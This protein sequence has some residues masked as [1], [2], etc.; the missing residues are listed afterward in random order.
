[1]SHTLNV[2]AA[3]LLAGAL[4]AQGSPIRYDFA[5]MQ[6]VL[7]AAMDKV[8]PSTVTVQ[9][10]GGTRKTDAKWQPKPA[11][12]PGAKKPPG[13]KKPPPLGMSGFAQSHGATT[14]IVLSADGWVLISKFALNYDPTTILITLA[15]GRSFTAVR[16]G[17]DVS[18]QIALVKVDATDLPV[19]EFV[20][21]KT[22]K[23]GS[24]AFVLGRT[25]GAKDP[26]VHMGVVSATRRVFGRALQTDAYTSP[27]NYGG[28]VV[29]IE[30]RVMGIAVPMDATGRKANIDLYD[31][32]IGFAATISD[33]PQLIEKMKA[34][35]ILHRGYLGI[36]MDHSHLGPGA[37]ISK[38][39]PKGAAHRAGLKKDDVVVEIDGVK[40][41]NSFHLQ[42]LVGIKMAGDSVYV[43]VRSKDE[44]Y[45]LTVFLEKVP[46]AQ[47]EAKKP[48]DKA[49]PD[50]LPWEEPGK[51]DKRPGGVPDK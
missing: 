11:P 21:P 45:G 25:F 4:S 43:K 49:D 50:R 33:I 30:G 46:D 38:V 48:A 28:P 14:G 29:D 23:V 12:T 7:H 47:M 3:T 10:F 15:D 26:S 18:R 44:E 34:G 1:M 41:E 19:P 51:G 20:D 5:A 8:G 22:I 31:S 32:G 2:V 42:M 40:V 24:W 9:T 36:D 13:K 35:E 27:A 6:N 17:E 16:K 37:K 39:A